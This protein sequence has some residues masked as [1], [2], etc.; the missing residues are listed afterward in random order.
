MQCDHGYVADEVV[1]MTLND[2]DRELVAQMDL[3]LRYQN[4]TEEDTQRLASARPHEII[5][6]S[7]QPG[8]QV[9]ISVTGPTESSKTHE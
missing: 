8:R 6:A 9:G 2:S 1:L 5:V 4:M 3:G 7:N